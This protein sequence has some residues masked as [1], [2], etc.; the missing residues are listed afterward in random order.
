MNRS[1]GITFERPKNRH[2][3]R[4]DGKFQ[5]LSERGNSKTAFLTFKTNGNPVHYLVKYTSQCLSSKLCNKAVTDKLSALKKCCYT[6]LR[7][8]G[9]FSTDDSQW[10]CLGHPIVTIVRVYKLYLLTYLHVTN[11]TSA[12]AVNVKLYQRVSRHSPSQTPT[13]IYISAPSQ[14]VWLS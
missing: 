9:T 3:F 8:Y 6:T 12:L 1:F 2:I 14:P 7:N 5:E 11:R 4:T 13:P 10:P